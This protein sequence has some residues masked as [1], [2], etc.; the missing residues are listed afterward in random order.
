M[1]KQRP[2]FMEKNV[3][4]FRLSEFCVASDNTKALAP[5]FVHAMLP[6]TVIAKLGVQ[7]F[8]FEMGHPEITHPGMSSTSIV[9]KQGDHIAP[10]AL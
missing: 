9:V 2:V 10:L 6:V 7:S 4:S 3:I 5:I 8:H 1:M